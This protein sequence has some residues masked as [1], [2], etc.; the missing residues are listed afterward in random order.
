MSEIQGNPPGSTAIVTDI[1]VIDT[2]EKVVALK[3]Q[4][5]DGTISE[6]SLLV[7]DTRERQNAAKEEIGNIIE[8]VCIPYLIA[9]DPTFRAMSIRTKMI[10]KRRS[11]MSI[12]EV[13]MGTYALAAENNSHGTTKAPPTP[14]QQ[15]S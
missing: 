4:A 12:G 10:L 7:F 9:S 14:S 3:D 15:H 8:G 13:V 11:Q 1:F 5:R 6:T 2:P